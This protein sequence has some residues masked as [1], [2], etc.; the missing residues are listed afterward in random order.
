[1]VKMIKALDSDVVNVKI[2]LGIHFITCLFFVKF[3]FWLLCCF[4]EDMVK[5]I[6]AL[7]S[8]MVNF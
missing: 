3:C 1:M 4:E 6:A 5:I 7:D 8:D 2:D